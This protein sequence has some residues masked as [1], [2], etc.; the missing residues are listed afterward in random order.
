M[1]FPRRSAPRRV[2]ATVVFEIVIDLGAFFDA[3]MIIWKDGQLFIK[4]LNCSGDSKLVMQLISGFTW[5]GLYMIPQSSCCSFKI[6]GARHKLK[7]GK[8]IVLNYSTD[9]NA[10]F[11]NM[12]KVE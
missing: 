6:K 11:E 1:D 12:F 2:W 9:G 3:I 8:E 10:S 4:G 5:S 7:I